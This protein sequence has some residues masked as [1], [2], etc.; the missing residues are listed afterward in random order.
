MPEKRPNTQDSP[1]GKPHGGRPK[2]LLVWI[3]LLAGMMFFLIYLNKL[4]VGRID[5]VTRGE[6]ETWVFDEGLAE[7]VSLDDEHMEAIWK[8][9][10]RPAK[11]TNETCR[12]PI[13][14]R[15]VSEITKQLQ[16]AK[17]Q[18][19]LND[20]N[21]KRTNWLMRHF[22]V[23]VLPWLLILGVVWYF[24]F[25]R[26]GM[27]GGPGGVLAF[28]QSRAKR[29]TK[30]SSDITFKDVA[31]M[32]EA[33]E[34]VT[35]IVEFLRTPAKFQ[36]LGGRIPRGVILIGAPGTGKTLLAKAI[37]GEASVPFYSISGS[38]FVEM[39]VGVGAARVRDLFQ[40]AREDSPSIIFLDE[41]D[42]VGRRRGSGWG[43][44]HDEREQ[45]LNAMLVEMDGFESD[46]KVIIIAA[47]NRPDVL[48]PALLRPGRFDREIFIDLPDLKA[49]EAILKV[50]AKK[51]KLDPEVDLS[52]TAR[53]TPTF[54][55]A[56][57]EAIIN[58]AALLDVMNDK[59]AVGMEELEE[60][61]DKVRWGRQKRSRVMDEEDKRITAYHESGHA[62]VAKLLSEVEPLHKV[63]I[64]PRGVSLGATMQI[65]EK[66][67]YHMFR[68]NVLGNI[69][70]LLAGRVAEEIFCDDISSG[71]ANDI[72]RATSLARHMV[73]EW[74]MS[75]ALGPVA[76]DNG[77]EFVYVGREI[78]RKQDYSESIAVAIDK[79]VRR[80][81]DECR[82]A[83]R[84][85]IEIN[86]DG[87][88]RITEALLLYETLDSAEVD[89]LLAGTAP[90]K[91]KAL[92][93][94]K[95]PDPENNE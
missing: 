32:Q 83:A 79:E 10:I 82:E 56:D 60:S 2:Q 87:V 71:A 48:D 24:L 49:R 37:A 38:D 17:R 41:I 52:V 43:G 50:H 84:E 65:P 70:T 5:I 91:L 7:S 80:V 31:G 89:K 6:F 68:K 93:K 11:L 62:L 18:G 67:K 13:N 26:V 77:E 81:I 12:T 72:N 22:L 58:E 15:E 75:D 51:V 88:I 61:R 53:S 23:N 14:E 28:G 74:G 76:Y 25:R 40:K 34:E 4:S 27:G 69:K 36:R 16:E 85:L 59:Q 44:G 86:K 33:K 3:V 55:G 73:C 8:K 39:F 57:L 78:A 45:T 42:A 95:K 66:D 63:T 35:E 9:D 29:M 90:D 30:E 64:I 94:S 54:S 46:E 20:Y 19:K 21:Y 47:T 92:P 1:D